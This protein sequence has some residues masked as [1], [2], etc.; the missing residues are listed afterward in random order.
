MYGEVAPVS[1]H[2]HD[3]KFTGVGW[4]YSDRSLL[5]HSMEMSGQVQAHGAFTSRKT[6]L[7]AGCI[8]G[9]VGHIKYLDA[10]RKRDNLVPDEN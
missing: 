8:R 7:R 2:Q 10:V 9:W 4:R 6:A 1:K 5:L 3:T